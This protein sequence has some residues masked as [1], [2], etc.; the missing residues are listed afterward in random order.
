MVIQ[1]AMLKPPKGFLARA[2]WW[3][4]HMRVTLAA[5]RDGGAALGRGDYAAAVEI[6]R[7]L[8]EQGYAR[9]QYAV[10]WM[11][12]HG[13]GVPQDDAI[14]AEWITK[15]AEKN[16]A[17]AQAALGW[18]FHNGRGRPVDDAAAVAWYR[19]AA[20]RRDAGA[21]YSLGWMYANGRGVPLN[22][23]RAARCW[24]TAAA[25]GNAAAQY[26]LSELYRE[27]H[28]VRRDGDRSLQWLRRSADGGEW[29]AQFHLG[30]AYE[31]GGPE[32]HLRLAR[33]WY[34][35]AARNLSAD[36]EERE[37]AA[38]YRDAVAA[39]IAG[40]PPRDIPMVLSLDRATGYGLD[41]FRGLRAYFFISLACGAVCGAVRMPL[42]VSAGLA[43]CV[44]IYHLWRWRS[45][46]WS[47]LEFARKALTLGMLTLELAGIAYFVARALRG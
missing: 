33:D 30:Y 6:L 35:R 47:R 31:V 7:P 1:R 4:S 42:S 39:T 3:I 28:G 36:D 15:A 16:I 8:A 44:A 24:R 41:R 25:Q 45:D 40:Q 20:S 19:K 43:L 2:K 23:V 32:G 34:D 29:S 21:R 22:Y 46:L 27:G 14:A 13:R 18:M 17:Q 12:L 10:G 38:T 37:T 9:Q 26:G 5:M 11:Y